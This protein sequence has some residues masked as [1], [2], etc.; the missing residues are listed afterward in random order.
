MAWNGLPTA[1]FT[2]WTSNG[3][4]I[5]LPIANVTNLVSGE[6]D[7]ATGDI[8]KI[9]YHLLDKIWAVWTAL[10]TAD[11]STKMTIYKSSS[12]N[13]TTGQ[14]THQYTVT[15]INEVSAQDVASE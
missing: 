1:W 2:G 11:K 7:V 9:L 8:R 13:V 14:I 6:A 15:F 10:A 3:T 12:T 5:T 4:N